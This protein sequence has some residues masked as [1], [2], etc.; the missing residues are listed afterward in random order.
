MPNPLPVTDSDDNNLQQH[1]HRRTLASLA[2]A[3]AGQLIEDDAMRAWADSL[4][5]DNEL[6]VPQPS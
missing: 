4:G 3:D 6:P 5:T 1:R 2:E